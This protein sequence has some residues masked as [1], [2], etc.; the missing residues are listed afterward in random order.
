MSKNWSSKKTGPRYDQKFAC[1]DDLGQI[2]RN[3]MEKSSKTGQEKKS[4][5]SIFECFLSAIAKV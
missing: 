2:I 5:V 1:S 4:S 3:K